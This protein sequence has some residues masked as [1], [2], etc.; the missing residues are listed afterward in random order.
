MPCDIVVLAGSRKTGGYRWRSRPAERK[1]GRSRLTGPC[2]KAQ[3][4]GFRG[5]PADFANG[6]QVD[7]VGEVARPDGSRA[8]RGRRARAR[9]RWVQ[10]LGGVPP[11]SPTVS[12]WLAWA[13]NSPR[14]G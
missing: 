14:E 3:D 11:I 1:P 4:A 13:D 2:R 12:R 8:A 5:R 9:R 6:I 10:V 7:T